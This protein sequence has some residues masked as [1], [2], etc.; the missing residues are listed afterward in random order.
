MVTQDGEKIEL[1]GDQ[2]GVEIP[3]SLWKKLENAKVKHT[4]TTTI[5]GTFGVDD[6]YMTT[7]SWV[8]THEVEATLQRKSY[9][10]ERTPGATKESAAQFASD[11]DAFDKAMLEERRYEYWEEHYAAAEVPIPDSE[12]WRI[13]KIL[14]GD[15]D[16]WL[17]AN[18][19]KYGYK[20]TSSAE[21]E[22]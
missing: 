11:F 14:K 1:S 18:A 17:A 2:T 20:Y 6:I 8:K 9:R 15:L 4:H 12:W 13:D 3:Q 16:K 19:E 22:L 7:E 10:L 5:G 21:S